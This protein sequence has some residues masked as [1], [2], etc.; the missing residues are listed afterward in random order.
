MWHNLVAKVVMAYTTATILMFKGDK[1]AVVAA[2]V[3]LVLRPLVGEPP[4]ATL[5]LASAAY[6]LAVLQILVLV[7]CCLRRVVTILAM[8]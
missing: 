5:W 6:V 1:E 3:M 2:A 4:R 7:P 8:Q